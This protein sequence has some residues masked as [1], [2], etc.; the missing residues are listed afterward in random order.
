[1][2]AGVASRLFIRMSKNMCDSL[3]CCSPRLTRHCL[4]SWSRCRRTGQSFQN[5]S[6]C[7]TRQTNSTNPATKM[8]V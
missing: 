8:S 3:C 2:N 6:F 1:M 7:F 4:T 5:F